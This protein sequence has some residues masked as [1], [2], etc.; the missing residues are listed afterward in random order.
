MCVIICIQ[1][2]SS[3]ACAT[4]IDSFSAAVQSHD[5]IYEN[6]YPLTVTYKETSAGVGEVEPG[7]GRVGGQILMRMETTQKMFHLQ[8]KQQQL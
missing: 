7:G 2:E 4:E 3:S 8:R 6:V 1:S 5:Q